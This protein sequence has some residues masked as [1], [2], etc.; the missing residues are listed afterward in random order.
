MKRFF[1]VALFLSLILLFSVSSFAADD[2]TAYAEVE[3]TEDFSVCLPESDAAHAWRLTD[4]DTL[5]RIS[6]KKGKT[7]SLLLKTE[8]SYL[9]IAWFERPTNTAISFYDANGAL[10]SEETVSDETKLNALYTLP[11]G[12]AEIRVH[13]LY[14]FTIS[15]LS[16]FGEDASA[17]DLAVADGSESKV[18]LMVVCAH[19]GD[20]SYSF[21]G[22]LPIYAG[23]RGLET[24]SVFLMHKDR[25]SQQDAINA[26]LLSGAHAEPQFA[27]Y[28]YLQMYTATEKYAKGYFP[29][30]DAVPYL[31]AMIRT[32]RPEVIVT[33][34]AAGED[35]D[36]IHLHAG[37]AVLEAI[38]LA[39]DPSYKKVKLDAWQV[40]KV[41][42]HSDATADV[43]LDLDAVST[44]F[45]GK[46]I[47]DVAQSAFDA[48]TQFRIYKKAAGQTPYYALVSST[49]GD[50]TGKNDL[51]EHISSDDLTYSATRLSL[52]EKQP[53]VTELP[54]AETNFDD[55]F[56]RS[57]DDPAEVVVFDYENGHYEYKSDNLSILIDRHTNDLPLVYHVV[58]IRMRNEDAYRP[59][60]ATQRQNGKD[61]AEASDIA[62]RYRAVLAFSGDNIVQID[63]SY[64]GFVFRDGRLFYRK[65]ISPSMIFHKDMTLSVSLE[66]QTETADVLEDGVQNTYSFGPPL[67]IDSE[68]YADAYKHRTNPR[69]PR[70]GIGMIE[71]GHYVVIQVDGRLTGY[72][73]GLELLPFA[74]MFADEGCTVAYNMDGG[75]SA[76]VMFMGEYLNL[77]SSK[78]TRKIPDM[79]IFGYSE[80]VPSPSDPL[81]YDGL[82]N[83]E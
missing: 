74:Q 78:H 67:V 39:G 62:R 30:R 69:N 27:G 1:L 5:S 82:V 65:N 61:A 15:E 22:V 57:A 31:I 8:L 73:H 51:F 14:N 4:G 7:C 9:K 64:K 11:A 83:I 46:T 53:A 58:H 56:F 47:R 34:A 2:E 37:N 25:Q 55:S 6:F 77:R 26:Q 75:A 79:M 52:A 59:A 40:K 20:E 28:S 18:D 81:V 23:E 80:N 71:P 21:G 48:Y 24:M 44:Q 12:C 70:L 38:T 33:H 41:Y 66:Y 36:P 17:S 50:D 54:V 3:T 29:T 43:T 76:V 63:T 19:T 60:F 16:V 35:G 45:G 68:V 32:Y 13:T 10:L 49:V 42:R 72:S